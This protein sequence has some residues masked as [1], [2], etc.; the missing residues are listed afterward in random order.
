MIL[1]A[2]EESTGGVDRKGDER[3]FLL[4]ALEWLGV[5]WRMMT[6]E[7]PKAC[8]APWLGRIGGRF[9]WWMKR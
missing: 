7:E 5:E 2:M 6:K 8:N 3:G 9:R 1:S 4:E